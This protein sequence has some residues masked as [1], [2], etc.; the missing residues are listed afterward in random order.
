MFP[1][2]YPWHTAI[3]NPLFDL[4]QLI[5]HAF[6]HHHQFHNPCEPLAR[7]KHPASRFHRAQSVMGG[8]VGRGAWAQLEKKETPLI[9]RGASRSPAEPAIT[10]HH[11][12]HGE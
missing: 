10:L 9:V 3:S 8:G 5:H 4:T 12:P 2:M 7:S 6:S 1:P 11:S